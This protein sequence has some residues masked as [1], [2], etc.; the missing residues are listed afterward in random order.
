MKDLLVDNTV[1]KNFCNSLDPHY[2]A[3]IQWLLL[4]GVSVITQRLIVEYVASCGG[5]P[6]NTSIPTIIDHLQRAGR[7]THFNSRQLNALRFPRRVARLLRSNRNDH[8]SI[9][10][11]MLSHRKYALSRDERFCYDVNYYP[12]CRAR[13]ETRSEDLPY[14]D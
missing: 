8:G 3:F 11:V 14:A 2:K 6:S 13:A 7:L 10:A 1:A 9:K 4:H 12:G 5:S